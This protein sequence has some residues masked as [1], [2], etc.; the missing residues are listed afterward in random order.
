MSGRAGA[1]CCVNLRGCPGHAGKRKAALR[2]LPDITLSDPAELAG[3]HLDGLA[4]D[5]GLIL[6]IIDCDMGVVPGEARPDAEAL[7]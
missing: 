3:R 2:R 4:V 5:A 1:T 7:G 6:E